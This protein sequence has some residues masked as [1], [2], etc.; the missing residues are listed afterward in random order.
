MR[1]YTVCRMVLRIVL[2]LVMAALHAAFAQGY[3]FPDARLARG[4]E[5]NNI[6]DVAQ[7]LKEKANVTG[8]RFC[9]GS[10]L[11]CAAPFGRDEFIFMMVQTLTKE[12]L[13]RKDEAGLVPLNLLLQRFHAGDEKKIRLLLKRGASP[14]IADGQGMTAR[15]IACL[16]RKDNLLKLTGTPPDPGK[17]KKG[18]T[19]R[20]VLPDGRRGTVEKNCGNFY[21]VKTPGDVLTYPT[22]HVHADRPDAAQNPIRITQSNKQSS[23]RVN[24]SAEEKLRTEIVET[25]AC[26]SVDYGYDASKST[27]LI[28]S[29]C[30]DLRVEVTT[31]A[32]RRVRDL[33]VIAY[34]VGSTW[35]PTSGANEG[36]VSVLSSKPVYSLDAQLLS[37]TIR[38]S[39][40]IS[41]SNVEFSITVKR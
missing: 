5:T 1:S 31:D 15:E 32:A 19:V 3:M 22:A 13:N 38:A 36:R 20:L 40:I 9:G 37:E 17:F 33:Y 8:N 10:C 41:G 12:Q 16:S 27:K 34:K 35:I 28:K 26:N 4:I 29:T 23:N 2:L 11:S 14:D 24:K 21:L 25:G 7:A 6:A 39:T 18:E 30:T